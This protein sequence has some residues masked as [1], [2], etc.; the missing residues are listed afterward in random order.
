MATVANKPKLGDILVEASV[1]TPLELD[2]GMQ[3][4]RLTGDFLG[5][6]LA[7]MELCTEQDVL[8]ALGVQQGM[9]R[10]NLSSLKIKDEVL[11]K[12]PSDVAKFYNVVPIR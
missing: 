11:R 6:V 5:R 4:Q 12:L 9:E 3:R 10:V 2:E 1:I 8:E 7:K